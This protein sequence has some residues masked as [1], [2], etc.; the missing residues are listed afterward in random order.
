[1]EEVEVVD[2]VGGG[3]GAVSGGWDWGEGCS[4]GSCWEEFVETVVE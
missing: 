1:M 3:E 2:L 4:V